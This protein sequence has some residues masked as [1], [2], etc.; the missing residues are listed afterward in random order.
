MEGCML[1]NQISEFLNEQKD[2]LIV[3]E[4]SNECILE[5]VY[6]FKGIYKEVCYEKDYLLK[7]KIFLS[8]PIVLPQVYSLDNYFNDYPHLN[9][10]KSFC[11]GVFLDNYLKLQHKPTILSFFNSLVDPYLYSFEYFKETGIMPF[12]ERKH[13]AEGVLEFYREYFQENDILKYI[14]LLQFIV[15]N[16][17][18]RGHHLCPCGSNLITRKCHGEVL[19]KILEQKGDRAYALLLKKDMEAVRKY[20]KSKNK[21]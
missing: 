14:K 13:G 20:V 11:L 5:G 17:R 8:F 10:D 3:E 21:R 18:Y 2:I 4:N 1:K 12:G 6:H 19:K 15:Q 7:I 16:D 9:P